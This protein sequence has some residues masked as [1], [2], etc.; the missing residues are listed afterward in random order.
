MAATTSDTGPKERPAV[1]VRRAIGADLP[2]VA[3]IHEHAFPGFVL[4]QLGPGF[5]RRY[6]GSVMEYPR[7]AL[8]VAEA[9]G[10]LIGFAAGF[11]GP[12]EFSRTLKQ[13]ILSLAPHII[14]GVLTH[15]RI[16]GI[17]WQTSVGVLQGRLQATSGT[18]EADTIALAEVDSPD[19]FE[20]C[21]MGVAPEAQGLGAGKALTRAIVATALSLGARGIYLN[22][23]A[24][25]NDRVNKFHASMGFELQ[26][27]YT[28]TGKRRRNRYRMALADGDQA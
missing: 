6:Y 20:F 10:K 23:D 17:V 27:W 12:K 18:D 13:R 4:T 7:G 25:D 16:F 3:R 21:S 28:A 1:T 9:E 15:P 8:L 26:G 24:D 5:L 19:E 11:L 14:V 2:A 22:T